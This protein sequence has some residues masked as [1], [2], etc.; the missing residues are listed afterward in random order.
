ML[1]ERHVLRLFGRSLTW[2]NAT[3]LRLSSKNNGRV[4]HAPRQ[5]RAHCRKSREWQG[6]GPDGHAPP[7]RPAVRD[8]LENMSLPGWLYFDPEFFEAEKK[9]FLRA[10]PQVVCH[11]SEIAKAGEWRTLEYLGES[12]FAI[13]GDDGR[14]GVRERLPA[15]RLTVGRRHGRLRQSAD[16]PVLRME[17]RSGREAGRRSTSAG[18]SGPRGRGPWAVPGR[19]RPGAVPV[20]DPGARCAVRRGD[21]GSVRGRGRALPLGGS[22]GDGPRHPPARGR[23]T[24]RRSRTI[25]PTTYIPVGHRASRACS[26]ATTGSRRSRTSTGWKASWSRRNPRTCRSA[27]T[28]ACCRPSTTSRPRTS[29]SGSIISCSRTSRSISTPTRSTS[30]SSCR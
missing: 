22:S 2:P 8:P 3:L 1:V 29:A 14:A 21:D 6:Q 11:E 9:A 12:V 7:I 23:S 25:I 4:S 27:S 20:R 15:S 28:S 24:G 5:R 17:L 30:C 13:R 18:I 26:A 19:A 10:A 16:L